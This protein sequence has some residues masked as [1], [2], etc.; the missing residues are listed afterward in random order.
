MKKFLIIVLTIAILCLT[1]CTDSKGSKDTSVDNCEF[2]A[3][4]D[5][6]PFYIER[7]S[8]KITD[9]KGYYFCFS[10]R[11]YYFDKTANS[12]VAVCGKPDCE[13]LNYEPDGKSNDCN[14]FIPS[15]EYYYQKGCAYY[16][17]SIYMLG[18]SSKDKYTV[19]L[20]KFSSDGAER[21]EICEMFTMSDW[22]DIGEFAVHRGYAFCSLNTSDTSAS[23]YC[24]DINR[25][26]VSVAYELT[27]YSAE[28]DSIAGSGKYMYFSKLYAEDDKLENWN[29]AVCRID[30]ETGECEE[31]FDNLGYFSVLNDNVYYI[32]YSDGGKILVYNTKDKTSYEFADSPGDSRILLNDGKN[33]YLANFDNEGISRQDIMIYVLSTD[34]KLLDEINVPECEFFEGGDFDMMFMETNERKLLCF[35]KSQIGTGSYEWETVYTISDN[36]EVILKQ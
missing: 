28:I 34:G 11:L 22:N 7:N 29:G 24:A 33:L 27:G 25:K 21:E 6:Q 20:F 30:I 15:D 3:G 13:H 14:A 23:L 35:D 19:S 5:D 32:G 16:N 1:A 4:S 18:K 2:T 9:G 31:L 8:M 12:C 17:G 26:S 10:D 36:G